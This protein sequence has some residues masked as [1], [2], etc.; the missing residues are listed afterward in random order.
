MGGLTDRLLYRIYW[1]LFEWNLNAV[2]WKAIIIVATIWIA[3]TLFFTGLISSI[4]F[5]ILLG[6]IALV[7]LIPSIPTA[8]GAADK[9]N[10]INLTEEQSMVRRFFSLL[11]S[12]ITEY[13]EMLLD[14]LFGD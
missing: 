7:Y 14:Y 9:A 12:D 1:F 6:F 5:G 4:G 2:K 3:D 11:F 13:V 8:I 10:F